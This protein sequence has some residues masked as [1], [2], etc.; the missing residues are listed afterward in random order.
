MQGES[1]S[2]RGMA[3]ARDQFNL[4]KPR[5]LDDIAKQIDEVTLERL[6]HVLAEHPF[7]TPTT[8]TIGEHELNQ[9]TA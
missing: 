5:T 7:T 4:G 3:I 2:A 1:T 8:L 9:A 6:N